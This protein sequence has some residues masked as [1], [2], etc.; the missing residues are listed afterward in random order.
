MPV[1][2]SFHFLPQ[3]KPYRFVKFPDLLRDPN[4]IIIRKFYLQK[5]KMKLIGIFWHT[6]DQ[7][8]SLCKFCD[9]RIW[10]W[11]SDIILKKSCIPG[12]P[13]TNGNWNLFRRNN[14][15]LLTSVFGVSYYTI[16]DFTPPLIF[17]SFLALLMSL[18]H[19]MFFVYDII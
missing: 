1:C 7:L 18:L 5:N 15:L 8:L 11:S 19:I 13:I 10:K 6:L 9:L 17:L 4:S 3:N 14:N 16:F 12:I 2:N